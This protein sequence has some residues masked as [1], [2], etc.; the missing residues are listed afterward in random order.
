VS[1]GDG[2]DRDELASVAY[3]D[4]RPR[5]ERLRWMDPAGDDPGGPSVGG[6]S[7]DS[8]VDEDEDDGADGEEEDEAGLAHLGAHDSDEVSVRG[9][10][11]SPSPVAA[12]VVRLLWVLPI[13][14]TPHPPRRLPPPHTPPH[15]SHS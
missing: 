13:S 2:G 1:N 9:P 10:S 14:A 15:L 5:G 6:F 8:D 3:G 4:P 7:S 12:A 11:P